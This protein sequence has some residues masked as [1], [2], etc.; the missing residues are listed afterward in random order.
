MAPSRKKSGAAIV[1]TAIDR[2]AASPG[3][4]GKWVFR[5]A[6][7]V[8][9]PTLALAGLEGALRLTGY[10]YPTSFFLP[11]KARGQD[12]IIEN[13]KFGWRFFGRALAR[14]PRPMAIP[15]VK[16]ANTRRIFVFGESAAFGDPDPDFG[17][18]RVLEVLL[19]DR[20]PGT[21]FEV[22]NAA[23]TGINS[24]VV[25]PIARDCA[26]QNGDVWVIY[27]GNNEVVGPFGSGTVFG[28][29]GASLGL[30]RGS[31]AFQATRT[32]ELFGEVLRRAKEGRRPAHSEWGGMEMFL[33]HQVRLDDPRM[34]TVYSHFEQN[35]ADILRI[36]TSHG[37]NIVVSTVVSNLKDC[38]PFA[39][40]HG[41]NLMDVEKEK[42]ERLYRAGID[43]EAAGKTNDALES[44]Q[45]A[46][47]IDP[48]FAELQYRLG[49]VCLALD[50]DEEARWYFIRARDEDTLRFRADSRINE[51]IRKSAGT[52]E[53]EHI[54]LADAEYV[55]GRKSPHGLPGD[56]LLHEHVHLNF[57]GNYALARLLA[58]EVA[59]LL[60]ES[61]AHGSDPGRNWLPADECG[62]RL[63]LTDWNRCKTA[64][65]LLLRFGAPPFTSQFNHAGHYERWK[66]E[67]ER[68]LPGLK[69][70]SVRRAAEEYRRAL[71]VSP[72]DWVLRKNFGELLQKLG[73]FPGAGQAYREVTE[74]LPHNPTGHLQLGLLLL[75]ANRLEEAMSQ[76]ETALTINPEFVPAINAQAL[77]LTLRGRQADA[78]REYGRALAIEPDAVETRLN[79]GI[80]LNALEKT[81]EATA[82]FR[83]A[84]QY[85]PG[86]ADVLIRLGKVAFNQGWMDH[87]LTNFTDA[88]RLDPTDA[89]AHFCL[90][91]ALASIGRRDEAQERYAEAVRLDPEFVDAR[92]GLGIEWQRQGRNAEAEKQF[93][94]ASRL[95]P[96]L[97]EPHLR[98]G[99]ALLRERKREDALN[100]FEEVLRLEPDNIAAQ[101]YANG[102]RAEQA[103]RNGVKQ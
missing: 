86:S 13:Q 36:G 41:P 32:G 19:R 5:M 52:R 88:V 71:V 73:D 99:L 21:R 50:R 101:K 43:A 51:I 58:D 45:A 48:H 49:Q 18:P 74:L 31:L 39:S 103:G 90:G 42:W 2:K 82:Q 8:L 11:G 96:K 62:R 12:I 60:P 24:H 92:L 27:M 83:Q 72:E 68:L 98:L 1:S 76:F 26:G 57:E 28:P 15:V 20:F 87:A 67:T 17:F 97:V 14:T 93:T 102:I 100:E 37:A 10:G 84:V 56:E 65:L 75:Q 47:K 95:A 94:E 35:L 3:H 22:V 7:M 33:G 55:L 66:K 91:G 59:K 64:K 54:I 38:A 85:H 29:Q 4:R 53:K 89:T 80:A 6:A 44:F 77:A 23:M 46:A 30:I 70:D 40:Q 25:L 9:A 69:M 16:P 81:N 34:E 78:L 79:L 61:A 63:A